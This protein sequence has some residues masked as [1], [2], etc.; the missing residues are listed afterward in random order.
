L[1]FFD[2]LLDWVVTNFQVDGIRIDTVKHI[3][4]E[5]WSEF[6]RSA[7]VFSIGEVLHGE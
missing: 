3:R 2:L 4:K 1:S 6:T 5:F 7:S